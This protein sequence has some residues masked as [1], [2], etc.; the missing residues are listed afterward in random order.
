MSAGAFHR[1]VMLVVPAS[2]KMLGASG[3]PGAVGG[4]VAIACGGVGLLTPWR[5][6]TRSCSVKVLDESSPPSVTA[7]PP[8]A[9]R[10]R[11]CARRRPR[12]LPT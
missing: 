12:P 6:S 5:F 10:R 4:D 8:E 7:V 3:G 1:S 11:R 9:T 2:P